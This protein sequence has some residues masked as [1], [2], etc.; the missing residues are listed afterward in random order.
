MPT[1][2]PDVEGKA[3]TSNHSSVI[4]AVVEIR[5]ACSRN[6]EGDPSNY[7]RESFLEEAFALED[8]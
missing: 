2:N 8:E 4:H 7:F 5:T 3:D 1:F 6:S